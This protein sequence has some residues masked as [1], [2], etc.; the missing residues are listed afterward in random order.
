MSHETKLAAAKT[1]LIAMVAWWALA[2]GLDRAGFSGSEEVRSALAAQ[3]MARDGDWVLPIAGGRVHADR[4]PM[5]SWLT[6][7]LS[8][9]TG[10]SDE[11]DARFPSALA[12]L[13]CLAA[14]G[15]AGGRRAALLLL[16][17]PVFVHYGRS[18]EL[19]SLLALWTTLSA[20]CLM[21]GAAAS[22]AARGPWL[23]GAC[24]LSGAAFMTGGVAAA[25]IPWL[26]LLLFRPSRPSG[27]SLAWL[28]LGAAACVAISLPWFLL[29]ADMDEQA[30][31]LLR[32]ALAGPFHSGGDYPSETL[33]RLACV[34]LGAGILA[35]ALPVALARAWRRRSDASLRYLAGF[36]ILAAPALVLVPI[37]GGGLALLFPPLALLLGAGIAPAGSAST[38]AR[39]L[40]A[41]LGASLAGGIV[42]GAALPSLI[43][44]AGS[45]ALALF[46][47][48]AALAA[49][50]GLIARPAARL[51][52]NG[53]AAFA[54]VVQGGWFL[55][56]APRMALYDGTRSFARRIALR[57]PSDA[58]IYAIGRIDDAFR[59][60]LDS[61]LPELQN[62]SE[63][64]RPPHVTHAFVLAQ[65][66]LASLRADAS[67][68]EVFSKD[69]HWAS[70][71]PAAL[72]EIYAD[73]AGSTDPPPSSLGPLRIVALGDMG[74]GDVSQY[75]VADQID[76]LD[77]RAPLD[78]ALFLGDLIYSLDW[79]KPFHLVMKM[80][81]PYGPLLRRG[82]PI[83]SILGNHDHDNLFV[84][85]N[86]PPLGLNGSDSRVLSLRG[87]LCDIFLADCVALNLK[88]SSL[89]A[90]QAQLDWLSGELAASRARWKILLLHSPPYSFAREGDGHTT[91][92]ELAAPLIQQHGVDIVLSGD[93][94]LYER[95]EPGPGEPVYFVAGSGGKLDEDAK[96]GH[97]P[98]L[99]AVSARIQAFLYLEI[100]PDR[101]KFRSIGKDGVDLDAGFILHEKERAAAP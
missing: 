85:L 68:G 61:T 97:D 44:L 48:G 19:G 21:R 49:R 20:I 27:S 46:F 100:E 43:A 60:Y 58:S 24:A 10:P 29:I 67:L 75:L 41:L 79:Y 74:T 81:L 11:S 28:G 70:P 35:P 1:I 45:V 59:F 95:I 37:G 2:T 8:G 89:E 13:A 93:H 6:A 64:P 3:A 72:F 66:G 47:L 63:L 4:P 36:A 92:R 17:S 91:L 50:Q 77:K 83:R 51:A 62:P 38:G 5:H 86:F 84:A 98:R 88:Y 18:A 65:D 22:G 69:A 42:F 32:G 76:S 52:F 26:P 9:A 78:G 56:G 7:A 23:F 96:I 39:A 57:L 53:L 101:V 87:G 30:L 15:L 99:K 55:E 12:A 31:G 82:L 54:I 16:A 73:R 94:H 71:R 90:R 40:P 25:L 80:E 33:R 14:I 34:L